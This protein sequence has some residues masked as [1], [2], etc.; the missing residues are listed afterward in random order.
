MTVVEV[1]VASLLTVI[2]VT[3]SMAVL[4]RSLR[5]NDDLQRRASGMQKSR[6][7]MDE[8]ARLLRSEV[9]IPTVPTPTT[10]V[11][12]GSSTSMTFYADFGDGTGVAEK[13]VVALDTS[14]GKLTDTIYAGTGSPPTFPSAATRTR[15]IADKIALNGTT[16]LFQFFG[17]DNTV[18]PPTPTRALTASPGW[19]LAATD[20]PEVARV[21][22]TLQGQPDGKVNQ[23]LATPVQDEVFIRL[24][25]PN[26][27]APVPRCA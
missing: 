23:R 19:T 15:T 10:P 14:T 9:C 2:I 18:D 17:F 4:D 13:H 11:V 8:L 24:A 22:I 20:A 5:H 12:A 6:M 3:A 25:N 1:L 21:V 7:A 27:S 16:P 26:D